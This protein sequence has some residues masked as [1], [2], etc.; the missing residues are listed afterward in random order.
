MAGGLAVGILRAA[1]L[2]LQLGFICASQKIYGTVNKSVTLYPS[3]SVLIKE[4]MWRKGKD[5]VV[6]W[7]GE[8]AEPRAYPPFL[9][10][11]HLNVTSGSLT[12]F[13]VTSLD[14]DEYEVD[15]LSNTK[16]KF[17]LHVLEPLPP[18]ALNCMLTAEDITVHCRVPESYSSHRNLTTY[19]WNCFSVPCQN[20]SNSSEVSIKREND[21]SQEVQCSISNP[22]ST[23][24]SS[25]VLATCV[26]GNSR[27]HFVI[28]PAVI[29]VVIAAVVLWLYSKAPVDQ[30]CLM[31]SNV[32]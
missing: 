31:K 23:Q 16:T 21:L 15:F 6:E 29:L 11:V 10:R 28:I 14:E 5:K 25:L 4:I 18:P 13:N 26:P 24:T 19:S 27:A 9:N 8:D 12:I 2:V 3:G 22:L 1:C 32:Q 7:D 20:S 17:C 30:Y